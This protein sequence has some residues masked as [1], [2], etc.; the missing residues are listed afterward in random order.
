MHYSASE[1]N[2]YVLENRGLM[3]VDSGGQYLG[4]TTDIT[5]TVVFDEVNEEEKYDFTM[6]L[7]ALIS[8][9]TARFLYGATGSNLDV[10]AR[11][12]LWDAGIDYKCGTGHGW[13]TAWRP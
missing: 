6:V 7:K 13:D 5:R 12:P 4:G 10:L 9:S 3:V 2:Q 11:K 1:K 8:L